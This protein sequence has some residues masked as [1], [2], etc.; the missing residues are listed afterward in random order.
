MI[1][2]KCIYCG[3]GLTAKEDERGQKGRCQKCGHDFFVPQK[4]L[5]EA[6][7][8]RRNTASNEPEYFSACDCKSNVNDYWAE[9]YREKLKRFVPTYD[10]LS[11]SLMSFSLIML[12][13]GN[14]PMRE[15]ICK[16]LKLIM[17]LY[18]YAADKDC[19]F[20][21]EGLIYIILIMIGLPVAIGVFLYGFGLSIYHI[22]T[23]R[24]KTSFE[25]QAMLIF[26]VFTNICTAALA[27]I[28]LL[29]ESFGL[30]IIF[31]IWNLINAG[32]LV[33]LV[34]YE[35]IDEHCLS[36]H[37]ATYP[38][39]IIGMTAIF[40]I[41]VFCNF[42]LNLYWAVTFSICIVYT[43]SFNRSLQSVF[44]GLSYKED[45]QTS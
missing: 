23:T 29:R 25:K 5:P 31:P 34:K 16:L 8:N 18:T 13:V 7:A 19:P 22:Y 24:E 2:F 37:E 32:L 26:A 41:F 4:P 20:H 33:E 42:V 12:L 39:I 30:T 28:H 3:H 44:P 11:L 9:F 10:E 6:D 1:Q 43:A 14:P 38:Q 17:G 40:I 35:M 15:E 21:G 27:G 36:D 45:K